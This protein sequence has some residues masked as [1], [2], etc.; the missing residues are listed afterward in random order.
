MYERKHIRSYIA[1][2]TV[3]IQGF[4]SARNLNYSINTS[5]GN[6]STFVTKF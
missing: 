3:N 2:K 1:L 6:V 5:R 4:I